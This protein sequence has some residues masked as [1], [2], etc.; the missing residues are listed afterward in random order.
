MA[1]ASTR[2]SCA[3]AAD[4]G[5][6]TQAG[7]LLEVSWGHGLLAAEAPVSFPQARIAYHEEKKQILERFRER[8]L[9]DAA[10][11]GAIVLK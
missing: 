2:T 7:A 5:G 11:R 6:K 1:G 4:G 8:A 9:E 3:T 10:E